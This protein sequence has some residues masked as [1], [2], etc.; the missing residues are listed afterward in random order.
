VFPKHAGQSG[1]A[2]AL[3]RNQ[4][5]QVGRTPGPAPPESSDEDEG[6]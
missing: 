5:Q 2:A 3:Q 4:K 6:G 1:S